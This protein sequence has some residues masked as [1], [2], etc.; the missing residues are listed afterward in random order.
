[1]KQIGT[2]GVG[3][4]VDQ[5]LC[6]LHF[7]VGRRGGASIGQHRRRKLAD[8]VGPAQQIERQSVAERH[9][10][11]EVLL[12]GDD[13]PCQ[14]RLAGLAQGVAQQQVGFLALVDRRHVVRLL[15]VRR[16]N[17]AGCDEGLDLDG[18]GRLGQGRADLLLGQHHVLAIFHLDALDQFVTLHRLAGGLADLQV[19]DRTHRGLVDQVE[20]GPSLGGGGVQRDRDVN[21]PEADGAL[22][23]GAGACDSHGLTCLE[24]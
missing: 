21:Q 24:S 12:G 22:P 9:Q 3:H 8:L 18:L 11:G 20:P 2:P 4:V 1:M 15:E 17:V 10:R 6:H 14:A 7:A 19:A 16:R 23:D 5:L 13:D